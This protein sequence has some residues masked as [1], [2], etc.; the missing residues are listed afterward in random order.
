MSQS[1]DKFYC[2]HFWLRK[3]LMF[4]AFF[5]N[6]NNQFYSFLFTGKQ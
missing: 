5:Q 3:K 1:F 6:H 2:C 4:D